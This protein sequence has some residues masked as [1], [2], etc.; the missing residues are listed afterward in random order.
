[1]VKPPERPR[2]RPTDFLTFRFWRYLLKA[3]WLY[4]PSIIFLIIGYTCFWKLTQGK[5]LMLI[6]LENRDVFSYFL[7]AQIFWAY[8]TWY[9]S[10]L[11]GKAEEFE[12]PC[13]DPIWTTLRI[14]GPRLLAFTSFTIIIFAFFQLSGVNVLPQLPGWLCSLFLIASIPVYFYVYRFWDQFTSRKPD[15]AE[16]RSYFKQIQRVACTVFA[17][18]ASLVIL[19]RSFVGL[20]ILLLML[21]QAL[22]LLLIIR[23]KIIESKGESFYQQGSNARGFDK[24]SPLISKSLGLVFDQED[25]L[26][27]RVFVFIGAIAIIVNVI[28]VFLVRFSVMIGSFPF[29]L[30]A[31]SVLLLLGNI[32]A[33]FSVLRHFNFHIILIGIAFTIGHFLEPHYIKMSEKKNMANRFL[34][35]QNLKEYFSH[36]INDPARKKI[37]DDS[38]ITSYPVFLTLADG[39][40]SRSGYWVASVL[41]KLED[42]SLGNF[43]Q[44]L[45]GLSG[46]S[47]GS[48]GNA[49]FFSLLKSKSQLLNIDTSSHPYYHAATNYLNSDF[50]TFTLARM[51]GPDVFRHIFPLRSIDDRGAA[52]AHALE[53]ACGKGDFL[54]D[55]LAVPFSQLITQKNQSGYQLPVFCINT[56]RMQDGSPALISNID[57]SDSAYNNRVD[58]LN[59]MDEEKDIKL[60]TAVVLGASFP[61]VSPAGR[62]D[63]KVSVK[64]SAG[65][66]RTAIEPEYFVDGGYFDNSGAGVVNE[67]LILLRSFL[68]NEPQFNKYAGKLKFYVVHISNS[69]IHGRLLS[70]VNP[71]TNDLAAPIKTLVGAYGSQTAV[72]DRRLEN[73]MKGWYGDDRHY[74]TINLYRPN[75]SIEYSMNW[76]ISNYLLNAMNDRLRGH[77]QIDTVINILNRQ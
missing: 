77:E 56:T 29:A 2:I 12:N 66:A 35:R 70:K 52:L 32:V 57:F 41:A 7:L 36:W 31:F 30:I 73:F 15:P 51:L 26:Y 39:G 4:F 27:F 1:M 19:F 74:I 67:M 76:V 24:N 28:T 60:S 37:L 45:F 14:Q 68:L 22:V 17:I 71:F 75:E 10:R 9:T 43:S 46:A 55:S 62:M 49:V 11:V 6:T 3:F 21:Q 16:Q 23:R 69:P 38:T 5:D 61:Y 58:V 34:Y 54:Y 65:V 59:L 25:R 44:H 72:N 42:S 48:V 47:G 53:T 18:A 63:A 8:A 64:D 50:L 20:V 33:F 13:E 40:A